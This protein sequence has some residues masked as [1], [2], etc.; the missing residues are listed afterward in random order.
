VLKTPKKFWLVLAKKTLN[1]DD[2]FH[3]SHPKVDFLSAIERDDNANSRAV[4]KSFGIFPACI[5]SL[6][7]TSSA[8]K[9]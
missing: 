8:V 1:N 4:N 7:I 2:A 9:D 5:V 6:I 3:L